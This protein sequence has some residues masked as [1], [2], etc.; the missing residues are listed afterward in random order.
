VPFSSDWSWTWDLCPLWWIAVHL[1]WTGACYQEGALGLGTVAAWGSGP[2]LCPV[3]GTAEVGAR[4]GL[5]AAPVPVVAHTQ[6]GT[7]ACTFV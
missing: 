5:E 3:V 2:V 6:V 7:L 4:V 1:C